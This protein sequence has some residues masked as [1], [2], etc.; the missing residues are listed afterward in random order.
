MKKITV[1][2]AYE[3]WD[4]SVG[5]TEKDTGCRLIH[6]GVWMGE[7]ELLEDP[8]VEVSADAAKLIGI[9]GDRYDEWLDDHDLSEIDKFCTLDNPVFYDAMT[10]LAE[11]LMQRIAKNQ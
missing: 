6:F 8:V 10:K 5:Y 4:S 1:E 7:H 3:A 2:K 11:G 9:R